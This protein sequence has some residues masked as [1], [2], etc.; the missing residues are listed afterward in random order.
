MAP[1]QRKRGRSPEP[2]LPGGRHQRSVAARGASS[3]RATH[4]PHCDVY[5]F[6]SE[7]GFYLVKDW[8]WGLVSATQVQGRAA[9]ALRDQQKLLRQVGANV[10]CANQSL[11]DLSGL[12]SSGAHTSNCRRDLVSMLGDPAVPEAHLETVHMVVAKPAPGQ[13]SVAEVNFPI[14][15]PHKHFAHL[16]HNHLGSLQ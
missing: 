13:P 3:S 11:Q 15:L 10:E 8:A 16:Y 9:M 5:T 14:L 7:Q 4:D 2:K 6:D 12:G 1:K